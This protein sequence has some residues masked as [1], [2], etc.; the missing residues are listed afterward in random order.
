[1]TGR[2]LR[3]VIVAGCLGFASG[4]A[5]GEGARSGLV[6][7]EGTRCRCLAVLRAG[8]GSGEFWPGMHAA[9]ALSL[10]GCGDEV[11]AAIAPR[12]PTEPDDQRRCGL[13]RE[14]VRAG[15]LASTRV[16]L[17]VL[18]K[19]DPH[20]HVH[21]CESLFKVW[22]VGDGVLLRRALAGAETPSL[23][24]MAAAALARWGNPEALGSIRRSVTANDGETAR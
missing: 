7:D 12:L 8:L 13:A 15:D 23:E 16:L 6:L 4:P 2:A 24:I 21:A 1:M 3:S 19:A 18:A 14:L 9:E 10:A 5:M 22:Q 17:D 11:R 20:G